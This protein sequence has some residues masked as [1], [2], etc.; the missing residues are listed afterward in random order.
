MASVAMS[1]LTPEHDPKRNVPTWKQKFLRGLRGPKS[2]S[3][4]VVVSTMLVLAIM[5]HAYAADC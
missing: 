2:L 1:D 5:A 4:L 3:H